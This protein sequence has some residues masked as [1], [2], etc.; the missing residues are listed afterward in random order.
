VAAG[1]VTTTTDLDRVILTIDLREINPAEL[2]DRRFSEVQAEQAPGGDA[3]RVDFRRVILLDDAVKLTAHHEVYAHILDSHVDVSLLCLAI[4]PGQQDDSTVALRRPFQLGPPKAATLWVGD[5]YGIGWRMESTQADQVYI[6]GQTG[7]PDALLGILEAL[8]IPQI[9]DRVVEMASSMPGAAAS[10][11]IRLFHGDLDP[12]VLADAQRAAIRRLTDPGSGVDD[13]MPAADPRPSSSPSGSPSGR[14]SDVI[15]PGGT[16]EELYKRCRRA[17]HDTVLVVGRMTRSR[18]LFR[19][20]AAPMRSAFG[21]LADSLSEF[22]DAIERALDWANPQTGFEDVHRDQLDQLGIEVGRPEPAGTKRALEDL[23]KVAL[24]ALERGQ[25]LPAIADKLRGAADKAVPQGT[26]PYLNRL[27]RICSKDM[28]ASLR[29]PPPFLSSAPSPGLLAA[30]FAVCLLSGLW[31]APIGLCG[32]IA[33]LGVLAGAIW[34]RSRAALISVAATGADWRFVLLQLAV[35]LAGSVCGV[36]LSRVLRLPE[37][38]GPAGIVVGAAITVVLVLALVLLWWSALG[39]RWSASIRL[40]RLVGSADQLRTLIAEAA[41]DEWQ[42]AERQIAVSDHARIMAG[43]FDD[44]AEGLRSYEAGLPDPHDHGLPSQERRYDFD[45]VSQELVLSDLADAVAETVRR[46]AIRLDNGSITTVLTATVRDELDAVLKSY[47]VHLATAGLHEPPPFGRESE[48]RNSL[49]RSLMERG[50]D[51]QELVRSDVRDEHITQLCAPE[52]LMLLETQAIAAELIK[53][54]PRAAQNF[55]ANTTVGRGATEAMRRPI[56]WTTTSPIVGVVRLVPLRASAV[57]EEWPAAKKG[58]P[59][60]T[61]GGPRHAA[62]PPGGG[63]SPGTPGHGVPGSGSIPGHD[64]DEG[65][66]GE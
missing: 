27:H 43:I 36:A 17:A 48:Q 28:L 21:K 9:F 63:T 45:G 30:T 8:R 4:G 1:L 34:L 29:K 31:P 7:E 13:L 52:H 66:D 18:G 20:D 53:F 39:R 11:G 23:D 44:A 24:T 3:R 62:G 57:S 33:L 59:G 32:A 25:P 14:A 22:S 40:N 6:P 5:K 37:P 56:E 16:I 46:I 42:V 61:G 2:V 26:G 12:F 50:S 35:A 64:E 15:R 55:V 51:M 47:R 60:T 54:A 19:A 38:N 41:R 10:P 58:G 65:D 49:V